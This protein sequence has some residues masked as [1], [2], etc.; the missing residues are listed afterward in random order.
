MRIS[1]DGTNHI[2]CRDS[3]KISW[4]KKFIVDNNFFGIDWKFIEDVILRLDVKSSALA[5]VTS[6][7]ETLMHIFAQNKKSKLLK[8]YLDCKPPPN[9]NVQD[10]RGRTALMVYF[11]T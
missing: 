5:E 9:F 1:F 2:I 3:K 11:E 7:G 4:Y 8:L 6:T 10:K